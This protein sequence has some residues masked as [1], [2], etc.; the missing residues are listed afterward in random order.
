MIKNIT[1]RRIP[2]MVLA[3]LLLLPVLPA[4]AETL[5][6]MPEVQTEPHIP[7]TTQ[8]A[9]APE[10]P[11]TTEAPTIPE[12]PETNQPTEATETSEETAPPAE[13]EASEE[14]MPPAETEPPVEAAPPA[15]TEPPVEAAPP[16]ETEPPVET[17]APDAAVPVTL[18]AAEVLALEAGSE[19]VTTAGTVVFAAGTQAILQDHTGGIRLSFGTAPQIAPGDLLTVTGRRSGGF[20]VDHFEKTGSGDLPAVESSLA[21]DR[22]NQRIVVRGAVLGPRSLTQQGRSYSLDGQPPEGVQSGDTVDVWGVCIDG[23]FYADTILPAAVLPEPETQPPEQPAEQP[24]EPTAAPIEGWNF[25]FGQLHAHSA[26]SDGIGSPEEA[27][28]HARAAENL[29]FFALTD[30][31][32]S[33]DNGAEGSVSKDGAA[34]SAEWAAGKAAAA[35]VTDETFVG[36]FGY[37]MTWQETLAIGHISTFG[38]PGWQTREQPGMDTLEGYLDALAQVPGSVSQFNHP[39]PFY[40]EFYNFSRYNAQYDQRI[41]LLEVGGEGDFTAYRYYTKALDKGWHLAPSNNQNNHRGSWGTENGHRTVVLAKELTESAIYD[42]V[43]NYRVYATEDA[44]LKILY[45]LNSVLMGQTMAAA[46]D[47]TARV[48]LEDP[49]DAGPCLVEVITEGGTVAAAVSAETSCAVLSLDVAGGGRYCYLRITQADGDVA[50]TAP[51]WLETYGDLGVE[52]FAAE[53]PKPEVGARAQLTLTLYNKESIPFHV[54]SVEFS[55]EGQPAETLAEP[56]TV[57]PGETLAI[58]LTCTGTAPGAMEVSARISGTIAGISRSWDASLTLY[59]QLPEAPLLSIADARSLSPGEPCRVRG[60]VTAG[61]A[62]ACNSFP[63]SI[64][65]QDGT[66]GIQILDFTDP[67][68][69]VGTPMEAEGIL[70]HRGGNILL[71]LTDYT[72]LQESFHRYAPGVMSNRTAMDYEANSGELMQIEGRVVSVTKTADGKGVSRFTIQDIHGDLATVMVEPGI[73]SGAYG[74]NELASEVKVKRT[75]RAMGLVHRDEFGQTVLRVRNCDEVV[76]VPPKADPTNPKTGD[77]LAFLI[78][79][80]N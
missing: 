18:T 12:A 56:G 11:E 19:T 62:K 45:S 78:L 44:D 1:R 10:I 5:P 76:Y 58:P 32:N 39:G 59:W 24:D 52:D 80:L 38:T 7:E 29:D 47:L 51:V 28:S 17:E 14:T 63:E 43:R 70:L 35:A 73:G 20:W 65:L 26:I 49:T 68:I 50:V 57:P 46:T 64:Y 16:A 48:V 9:E 4:A 33:F 22:S 75:V 13:T 72:L 74:T 42:A 31:S 27:F 41:H 3:L 66:G 60:Y 8:A 6:A 2:A 23:V 71:A 34:L 25:Y 15:E 30:H 40:G 36:I 53:N 54:N 37:E 77:F 61:T 55:P 67:G 69:Q 79:I 21:E